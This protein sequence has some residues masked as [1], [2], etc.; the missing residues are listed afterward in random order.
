MKRKIISSILACAILAYTTPV[1]ALTKEETVYTKLNNNGANYN[2][3]VNNHL[4]NSDNQTLIQDLSDLLNIENTN[5]TEELERQGNKLVWK[6]NG[7]DIYY[8]GESNKK[9]P[10]DCNI[11]YELD[12]EKIEA[13]DLAGK[14]GK[15]K[16]T[17]EYT[18]K[19]K[20]TV[21]INGENQTMY[22]PFVTLCGTIINNENNKNIQITNGKVIDNGNKTIIIGMSFPGLQ[23]SLNISEKTIELPSKVEITM[24]TTSFELGNIITMATPKVLEDGDLSIFHELDAIYT[25][26]NTLKTSSNQLVQGANTLK[27]GTSTY[28]QKSQE[29]NKAITN[30]L[31]TASTQYNQIDAGINELA[32]QCKSLPQSSKDLNEGVKAIKSNLTQISSSISKL[33][34]ANKTVID[35]QTELI[36]GVD[37]LIAGVD[38]IAKQDNTEELTNLSKLIEANITTLTTTNKALQ[39]QLANGTL[40]EQTKKG[41]QTQIEQ[42]TK[43]I[44]GLK[45]N[46][47]ANK[48]AI[49]KIEQTQKEQIGTLQAGL[50][51]VKANLQ[52]LQAGNQGIYENQAKIKTW[53]DTLDTNMVKLVQGTTTLANSAPKLVD[54]LQKLQSG[55]SQMKQGL[56]QSAKQASQASIQ[57]NQATNEIAQ[58]AEKLSDGMNQFDKQG[59]QTIYSYING[60]LKELTTRVEKLQNLAESYNNF[61]MLNENTKGNV[62]FIMITDSI[63]KEEN[64]E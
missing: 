47:A 3:I 18:N 48:Q 6:A 19:D 33:Q 49:S 64:Q 43:V 4:I 8:Q 50:Q 14:S 22:T 26:A 52:K 24:E 42:N 36:K 55:S 59:V 28:N 20:H 29:F 37:Q 51:K 9:L 39:A 62:K 61:T 45:Q 53:V 17:I 1:L 5:G 30:G 13:K 54:G 40:D 46:L 34:T 58:G 27:Q 11:T 10:I 25:K 21:K 57:L 23:E 63:K 2:T 7:N 16:I 38:A 32:K 41:L 44:E 12:G 31:T 56:T 35:G 60:N 15:V